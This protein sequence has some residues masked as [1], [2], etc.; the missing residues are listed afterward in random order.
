MEQVPEHLGGHS[1]SSTHL[2]LS[3]TKPAFRPPQDQGRAVPQSFTAC[4]HG[5]PSPL[6]LPW[7]C[8]GH[9]NVHVLLPNLASLQGAA[10]EPLTAEGSGLRLCSC[11]T[12]TS[13]IV[14]MEKCVQVT[15]SL[16]IHCSEDNSCF[17]FP[18]IH[19]FLLC[20]LSRLVLY[21]STCWTF[22]CLLFR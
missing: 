12:L 1:E 8:P 13:I 11:H 17:S 15:S 21:R 2:T 14:N 18:Y 3:K 6:Q 10:P 19:N 5:L 9:W 7:L 22:S 4:D 16:L 20:R